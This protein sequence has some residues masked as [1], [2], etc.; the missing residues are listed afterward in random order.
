MPMKLFY[1][2]RSDDYR[3]CLDTIREKFGMNEEVDGAKTM[4]LLDD[5]SR[6]EL[7]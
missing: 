6:I 3:A 7:V 5:E 1:H 4:L 2:V